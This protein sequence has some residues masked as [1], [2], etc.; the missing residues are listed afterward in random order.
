MCYHQF[1][2]KSI[3]CEENWEEE[4]LGKAR[5]Q[6]P[7][8][9]EAPSEGVTPSLTREQLLPVDI[10]EEEE[11]NG[12]KWAD[13]DD[14]MMMMIKQR[15]SGPS[16]HFTETL[17]HHIKSFKGSWSWISL[18]FHRCLGCNYRDLDALCLSTSCL[19]TSCS[20][21][22]CC[23]GRWSKNCLKEKLLKNYAD[24]MQV[25][26]WDLIRGDSTLSSPQQ[27]VPPLTTGFLY[28]TC[29]D[30]M[31]FLTYNDCSSD[32][33]SCMICITHRINIFLFKLIRK[34]NNIQ[35]SSR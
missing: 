19:L 24:W 17:A 4:R 12:S 32:N 6:R 9:T 30:L 22:N 5:G 35:V 27:N 1:G 16:L 15:V 29:Q 13:G 20:I 21:M 14:V 28:S 7:M 18:G 26:E 3:Q 23:P 31:T 33:S 11:L 2:F 8:Q 10:K 25:C 34:A